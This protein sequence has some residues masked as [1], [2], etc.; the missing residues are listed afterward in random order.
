MT[1]AQADHAG[2]VDYLEIP[3]TV[4]VPEGLTLDK[5]RPEHGSALWRIARDSRALDLNS[6]YSYL[7]WCRDYASTSIV[8]SDT[9]GAPTGFITG[10]LRP[11]EPTTLLIWQVAVDHAQRGRGLAAAMLNALVRRTGEELGV[12]TI[13]TT[14]TPDNT[15]SNRLFAAFAERHQAAVRR[16]VLFDSE[17]FPESGHQPE[18]LYRIGPIRVPDVAA[19]R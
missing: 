2:A 17:A 5:P 15:A 9:S 13:E 4:E 18:V 3:G 19:A 7:L 14:V 8:A 12:T 16:E 1:P 10:Y 11:D 6:S